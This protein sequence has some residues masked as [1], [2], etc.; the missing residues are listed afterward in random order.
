MPEPAPR[1]TRSASAAEEPPAAGWPTSVVIHGLLLVFAVVVVWSTLG[2]SPEGAASAAATDAVASSAGVFEPQADPAPRT[3]V[4][5]AVNIDK[6]FT[7]ASPAPQA[8]V[9]TPHDN[10]SRLAAIRARAAALAAK[11]TPP[12]PVVAIPEAQTPGAA[13]TALRPAADPNVF[14]GRLYGTPGAT[15]VVY[16][17]DASGSLIDTLPFV[18]IELQNAL[19]SLRPDQSYAVMFFGGGGVLEAP[20]VGMKSASSQAVTQT[21]QW[22]DPG[23]GKVIASGRSDAHSAVR[24]ALAYQPDAIVLLSD[25]ITGRGDAAIAQR[26]QLLNLIDTANTSGVVFHTIQVRQPDPLATS[27]RRGT[28]ETIAL[29]TGGVYRYVAEADLNTR[30][31]E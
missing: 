9:T 28:L 27:T 11:S 6:A 7:A 26:V 12:P 17:I 29:Q 30:P 23:S 13:R 5:P 25:G 16:L 21:T 20:P 3:A 18:Q 19:R 1:P 4:S 22:V 31:T 8:A 10:A 15:R 24:R 2:R 14:Y